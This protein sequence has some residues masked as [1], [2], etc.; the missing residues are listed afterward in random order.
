MGRDKEMF[1]M[2]GALSMEKKVACSAF[3]PQMGVWTI[4]TE[5]RLDISGDW[6]QS[7]R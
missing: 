7:S 1:D 2:P 6:T 4:L 3:G 5:V